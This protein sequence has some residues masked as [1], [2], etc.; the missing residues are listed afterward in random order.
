MEA[1]AP[2]RPR[3]QWRN[4]GLA[5]ERRTAAALLSA[6][7]IILMGAWLGG[8]PPSG[9]NETTHP[10]FGAFSRTMHVCNHVGWMGGWRRWLRFDRRRGESNIGQVGY[11][12]KEG[13]SVSQT[14]QFFSQKPGVNGCGGF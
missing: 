6:A 14:R 2:A 13:R 8:L 4:E 7:V 9:Q 12:A 1:A 3:E 11:V 5:D 10:H